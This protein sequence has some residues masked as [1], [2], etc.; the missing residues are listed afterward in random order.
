MEG[1]FYYRRYSIW[2]VE[3]F[4]VIKETSKTLTL[5]PAKRNCSYKDNGYRFLKPEAFPVGFVDSGNLLRVKKGGKK[6]QHLVK[7]DGVLVGEKEAA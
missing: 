2:E 4:E 6:A 5:S 7:W 3:F 1:I